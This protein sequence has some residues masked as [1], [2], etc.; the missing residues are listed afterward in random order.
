[1][2]KRT[3]TTAADFTVSELKA[4]LAA[5]TKI[6]DLE[7]QR[8]ALQKDLARVEKELTVL[9]RGAGAGTSNRK[10]PGRK[11]AAKKA[12]KRPARN[13]AA[14][15]ATATPKRGRPKKAAGAKGR[16][17]KATAAAT[18]RRTAKPAP[19]IESVVVDVIKA[20]GGKMAFQD[21]LATIQKKKLIKT[22]A[23][24]FDNVLR[25]TISTSD[26]IKRAARGIYRV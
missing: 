13:T 1:M 9:L 7:S 12:P 5:K 11:K 8:A 16:P 15:A 24:N 25:R 21:I 20:N 2:A 10:K 22:K 18:K 6:D 23:T 19:T 17:K 26:Q 4:M 14:K 3:K